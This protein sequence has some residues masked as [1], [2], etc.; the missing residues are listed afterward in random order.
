MIVAQPVRSQSY[1]LDWH[2][3]SLNGADKVTEKEADR[4]SGALV[5]TNPEDG[6][7]AHAKY[8]RRNV[9][10]MSALLLMAGGAAF[11][12]VGL[13]DLTLLW[14]PLRFGNTSWEFG[15]L[16]QT[17]ASIPMPALGVVLV[18]FGL[19]RH[20]QWPAGLMRVLSVLLGVCTLILAGMG[21]LFAMAARMVVA[22][23]PPEALDAIGRAIVKG[24][25]EVTA[26]SL[27][28]G[29]LAVMLWRGVE[30]VS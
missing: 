21:G 25:V 7:A 28:L 27:L 10:G 18:A 23:T 16:T 3:S 8:G 1:H 22:Q 5:L 30:K 24:G 29:G 15:T 4:S 9:E 12:I 13:V 20:P 11:A 17:F 19:A 2:G 6:R 26:Y 14:L